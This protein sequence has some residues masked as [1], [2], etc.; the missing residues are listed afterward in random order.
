MSEN[1][2]YLI[3]NGAWINGVLPKDPPRDIVF[4][5]EELRRLLG[6]ATL[7]EMVFYDFAFEGTPFIS[8]GDTVLAKEKGLH[9]TIEEVGKQGYKIKTL[10][11]HIFIY[12]ATPMGV[13]NGVYGFLEKVFHYDYFY[14]D[15]YEIDR[16]AQLEL[17]EL[18]IT[19]IPDVQERI[20]AQGYQC[21]EYAELRRF[22]MYGYR[23]VFPDVGYG[24]AYHNCF[25]YLPPHIHEKDHPKWYSDNMHTMRANAGQLCYTARGDKKEYEAMVETAAQ[26]M[27]K[28]FSNCKHN[29]IVFAL[30]DAWMDWNE[31]CTCPACEEDKEKHGSYSASVIRFLNAVSDRVENLLTEV[32]DARAHTFIVAFY[33]YHQLAFPPV[34]FKTDAEGKRLYQ[35]DGMPIIEF[36][37]EMK[38]NKHLAIVYAQTWC[39]LCRGFYD[40]VHKH[41]LDDVRAWN[42][43]GDNGIYLWVYDRYFEQGGTFIPYDSFNNMKDLYKFV[44]E[45]KV[46]W[47]YC[48]CGLQNVASTAF[49]LLKGYLHSKLGWKVDTN[50]K[51]LEKKFFRAM[52]G[53]QNEEMYDIFK[54][55]K[56]Y[57]KSQWE[58]KHMSPWIGTRALFLEEYWD[59]DLLQN[60]LLRMRKA[61]QK[62]IEEHDLKAAEH[63]WIEQIYPVATLLRVW[64]DA[65][66]KQER[67]EMLQILKTYFFKYGVKDL[68]AGSIGWSPAYLEML[69]MPKEEIW[70]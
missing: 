63:V 20:V 3:N 27:F 62:L 12:A 19:E 23:E 32:N 58:E 44:K 6:K 53:S 18:D 48:E 21:A 50:I 2:K 39:D 10:D 13:L 26:H 51:T 31:N 5:S 42:Q 60:W 43:L 7:S 61:E 55:M 24:G 56:A 33:A 4:A 28:V 67:E 25:G 17:P 59:K 40:P 29:E 14:K 49:G 1:K 36:D 16:V 37:P 9:T 45:H 69:G 64:R 70:K 52:Y 41:Y 46:R 15:T 38:F 57:S 22:R 34:T 35:A 65:F 68:G 8:L 66:S 54:E 30:N 47:L 11:G